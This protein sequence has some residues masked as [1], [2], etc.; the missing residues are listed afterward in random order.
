VSVP[1]P[2]ESPL[3][4]ER[5]ADHTQIDV[6][7]IPPSAIFGMVLPNL[8][9]TIILVAALALAA[10]VAFREVPPVFSKWVARSWVIAT[11]F[12]IVVANDYTVQLVRRRHVPRRLTISARGLE[13]SDPRTLGV[14]AKPPW[15][16]LGEIRLGSL[17]TAPWVW[18]IEATGPDAQC[19]PIGLVYGSDPLEMN[20]VLTAVNEAIERHATRTHAT[21]GKW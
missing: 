8:V 21:T 14:S 9:W 19:T 1:L 6:G 12:V 10:L 15:R 11:V 4:V 20:T 3:H 5:A 16:E 17:R 2:Y 18:R 7:P 13:Y